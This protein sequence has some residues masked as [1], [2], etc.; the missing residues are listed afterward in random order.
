MKNDIPSL[1]DLIAGL[2]DEVHM[3]VDGGNVGGFS[4]PFI[5]GLIFP[6]E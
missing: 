3:C 5:L 2:D 6:P 4:W 1:D